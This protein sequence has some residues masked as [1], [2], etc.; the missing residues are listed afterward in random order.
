MKFLKSLPANRRAHGGFEWPAEV[1]AIVEAPDWNPAPVCGGGLHGLIDGQGK[2]TLLNTDAD[3]VWYAFESVDADGRVSDDEAVYVTEDGGGK[4]KCRRA[5]VR[6]VGT[7]QQATGWL[8][9]S[10]CVGVNYGTATAGYRGTATA[11]DYGTA[12]AGDDGTATAG[13]GGTVILRRWNGHRYKY[14]VAEV[15]ENGIEPN[16]AYRLDDDGNFIKAAQ[17]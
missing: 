10:G 7:R 12:T 6:A 17:S 8:I 5:I 15:G 2:A 1:G 3:A 14:S 16:V 4:G 9:A 13:N 11:G